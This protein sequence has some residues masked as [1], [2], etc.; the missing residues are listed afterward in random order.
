MPHVKKLV[1]RAEGAAE[2]R[3]KCVSISAVQ[4]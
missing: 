2:R 4:N 3:Q 1:L